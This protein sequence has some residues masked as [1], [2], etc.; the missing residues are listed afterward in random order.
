VL[1]WH[2]HGEEAAIF[3]RLEDVA[4]LVAEVYEKNHRDLDATF[5][6]LTEAVSARRGGVPQI[7]APWSTDLRCHSILGRAHEE[8]AKSIRSLSLRTDLGQ[9]KKGFS[10]RTPS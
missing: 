3:T 8:E 10:T 4:Q 7:P 6:A 2:A 9:R 1:E 5:E